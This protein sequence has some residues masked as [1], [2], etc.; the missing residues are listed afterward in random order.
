MA[1][2]CTPTE[3]AVLAVWYSIFLGIIYK[4]VTLKGLWETLKATATTCGPLFVIMTAASI[5][6]WILT[7]EGLSNMIS[8]LMAQYSGVVSDKVIVAI[9]V[10]VFLLIG[11]FI[12]SSSAVLLLSPVVF[13]VIRAF[14][15][16]PVYFGV[17]MVYA[18]IIGVITPPFGI[19]LFVVSGVAKLPVSAVTKEAVR[20]LPMMILLCIIMILF[21]N[22]V[23]FLPNLLF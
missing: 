6:T 4:K 21:P 23:T 20:Y 11:C 14:G 15:I 8:S 16:D 18:L 22:I 1:G 5:F 17:L 10:V 19:C 2:I 12:D 7:R 9:C 3:A 13:P